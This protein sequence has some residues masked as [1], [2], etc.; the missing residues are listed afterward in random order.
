MNEFYIEI[1]EVTSTTWRWAIIERGILSSN[2]MA[3]RA[4]GTWGGVARTAEI[5]LRDAMQQRKNLISAQ[6]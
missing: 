6:G 3:L 5:A 1:H 2:P 4:V